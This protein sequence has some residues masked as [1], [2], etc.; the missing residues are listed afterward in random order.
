[1]LCFHAVV[2]RNLDYALH[3]LLPPVAIRPH[4]D[5]AH[6]DVDVNKKYERR[7]GASLLTSSI[8]KEY[9]TVLRNNYT[10]PPVP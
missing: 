4:S 1:M 3:R 5:Q 10:R 6:T 8:L 2:L 9:D 7:R